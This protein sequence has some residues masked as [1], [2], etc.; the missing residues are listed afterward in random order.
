MGHTTVTSGDKVSTIGSN[1]LQ[2]SAWTPLYVQPVD[3]STAYTV[4]G[5]VGFSTA[6]STGAKIYVKGNIYSTGNVRQTNAIIS[7]TTNQLTLGTTNT[8]TITSPAPSAS[9]TYTIPDIGGNGTFVLTA[10]TGVTTFGN[11]VSITGSGVLGIS[12]LQVVGARKTGYS[13][14]TGT[15]NRATNYNT[16]TITLEQLAERLMS[17]QFDMQSHGLIDSS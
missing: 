2:A 11:T 12:G 6:S 8:V 14:W 7:N 16:A 3:V 9:R 5:D 1:D 10:S 13:S 15:A 4:F 17:L